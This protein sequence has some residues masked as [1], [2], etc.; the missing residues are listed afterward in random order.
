MLEYEH[1]LTGNFI[2]ED[3]IQFYGK[4]IITTLQI[5]KLEDSYIF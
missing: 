3:D 5:A 1:M 2:L 4:V